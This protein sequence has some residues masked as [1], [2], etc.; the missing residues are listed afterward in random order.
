MPGVGG[1]GI[2]VPGYNPAHVFS[3]TRGAGEGEEEN[4]KIFNEIKKPV[5]PL[6][7]E[8]E[9]SERRGA[10][11]VRGGLAEIVASEG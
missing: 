10:Y 1:S 5:F 8:F 7:N 4:T 11:I 3:V 2:D 9:M 6:E